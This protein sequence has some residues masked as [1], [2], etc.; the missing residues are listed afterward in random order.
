M[1]LPKLVLASAGSPR[2]GGGPKRVLVVDAER[3]ILRLV[4]VNLE[5][6]GYEVILAPSCE[7]AVE[8]ART[9]RPELIVIDVG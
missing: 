4:Q 8:K 3:H 9:M 2:K 7:D 5:R 1:A 6:Q